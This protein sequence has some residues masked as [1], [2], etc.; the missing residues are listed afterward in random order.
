MSA[1]QPE[2]PPE[3]RH[4]DPWRAVTLLTVAF[5]AWLSFQTFQQIRERSSLQ[6]VRT[7]QETAI[8]HAQKVR[9]QF[10]TVTKGMLELAQQG[11][12]GAALI[13]E[14]LARRG[15]TIKPNSPFGSAPPAPS[16]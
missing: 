13:I 11:N 10:E 7:A 14:E 5:V 3:Q 1:D 16:K 9:G 15:V 4:S 6:A 2:S 8:G 12:A